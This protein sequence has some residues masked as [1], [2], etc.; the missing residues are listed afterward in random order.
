MGVQEDSYYILKTIVSAVFLTLLFYL[1]FL[2]FKFE[3]EQGFHSGDAYATSTYRMLQ[4]RHQIPSAEK[5]PNYRCF[6]A[7]WGKDGMYCTPEW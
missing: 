2:R 1:F 3:Y 7:T 4:T 5:F 6:G